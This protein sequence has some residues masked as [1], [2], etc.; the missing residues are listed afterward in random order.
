MS[1]NII[2]IENWPRKECFEHFMNNAG[3][4]YSITVNMDITN[5]YKFLKK[6]NLRMYPAFTWI[7]TKAINEIDEFKMGYDESGKLGYYDKINPCYSVLNSETKVMSDLCTKY[8]K[9]F[10]EFYYD[11]VKSLDSYKNDK[12]YK[13]NF[14]RNFFIVSC[15]PWMSYSSFNVN[16]EGKQPF[17]FPMVTWGKYFEQDNKIL[18]PVTIQIHHAVADGYHCSLFYKSVEEVLMDPEK[19]L[20]L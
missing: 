16:N 14:Y 3:C 13:T 12:S 11:M 4:S 20:V 8:N 9:K 18:I 19:Y 10:I 2:D 5:L 1:F 7:I 6:N 15:I 17:L